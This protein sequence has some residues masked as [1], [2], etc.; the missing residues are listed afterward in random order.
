MC[1]EDRFYNQYPCIILTA[2]GQPDVA[3]RLFLRKL[4]MALNYYG[5]RACMDSQGRILIHPL[6]REATA[7]NSEVSVLGMQNFL[8]VWNHEAFQKKFEDDPL[9]D[10]DLRDLAELGF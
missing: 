10:E 1:A 6:L 4:R 3:T 9:S 2:K 5:Q 8:E 7:I